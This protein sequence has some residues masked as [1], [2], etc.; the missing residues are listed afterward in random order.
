MHVRF[1]VIFEPKVDKIQFNVET[2]VLRLIIQ[3]FLPE[4]TSHRRLQKPVYSNT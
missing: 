3:Q 1:G 2:Y 4:S